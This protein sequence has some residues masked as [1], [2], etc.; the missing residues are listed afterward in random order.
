MSGDVPSPLHSLSDSALRHVRHSEILSGG[1]LETYGDCPVKWLVEREL[2]PARF[3]PDPD[4]IVRG[5][6]MHAV[7]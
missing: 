2:Q 3:E 1:A 6:Y 4:P 7:L 5:S